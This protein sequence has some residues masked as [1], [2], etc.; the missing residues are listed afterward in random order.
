MAVRRIGRTALF[1]LLAWAVVA[2]GDDDDGTLTSG[3]P[4]DTLARSEPDTTESIGTTSIPVV[5]TTVV[6]PTEATVVAPPEE[7]GVDP[8]FEEVGGEPAEELTV[9]EGFELDPVDCGEWVGV[10]PEA[11]ICDTFSRWVRVDTPDADR[12]QMFEGGEDIADDITSGFEQFYDSVKFATAEVREITVLSDT[13]AEVE[14]EVHWMDGPS[15]IF[16]DP[17]VGYAVW[18]EPR[19]R[20]SRLTSCSM[21]LAFGTDCENL[22]LSF[23]PEGPA[24]A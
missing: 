12:V 11:E 20:V 24:P 7:P 14:F 17:I 21:A 1:L 2:C 5:Q 13:A 10:S 23:L 22:D 6:A 19:W 18:S 8:D 3:E 4:V 9:I 15:P 16:P